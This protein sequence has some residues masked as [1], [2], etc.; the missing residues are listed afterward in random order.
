MTV[1]DLHALLAAANERANAEKQRADANAALLAAANERA[2]AEKQRADA[3]AALLAAANE[4]AD[5]AVLA[6]CDLLTSIN[7]YV[8][9]FTDTDSHMRLICGQQHRLMSFGF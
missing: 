4:R 9:S 3:N 6:A 1:E 8:S 5:A 2:N 7:M